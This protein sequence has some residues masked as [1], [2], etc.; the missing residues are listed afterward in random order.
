MLSRRTQ[1]SP[2]ERNDRDMMWLLEELTYKWLHTPKGQPFDFYPRQ[3]RKEDPSP[4][5]QVIMLQK[6]KKWKAIAL[7]AGDD[8]EQY[9]NALISSFY[10][11]KILKLKFN[12]VYGTYEKKIRAY[13]EK[14]SLEAENKDVPVQK[15]GHGMEQTGIPK[16][17]YNKNTGVGY[18]NGN[19]FHFRYR[20]PKTGRFVFE[21]MFENI[22][23]PLSRDRI[24]EL[25]GF[26]KSGTEVADDYLYSSSRRKVPDEKKEANY[27]ICE[28]AKSL[29]EKTYLTKDEIVIVEEGMILVCEKLQSSPIYSQTSPK[30]TPIRKN[31]AGLS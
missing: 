13:D 28:M 20:S 1:I 31:D 27:F 23:Q 21:A 8:L 14:K 4:D 30:R 10:I 9:E 19:R 25:G 26:E 22:N 17:H 5:H 16:I 29:R 12:K 15:D 3:N 24:L 2:Q 18:T 11:I 6:L 7:E